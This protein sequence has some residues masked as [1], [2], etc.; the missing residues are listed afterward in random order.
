M[1]KDKKDTIKIRELSK[2][3]LEKITG[4]FTYEGA[5]GHKLNGVEITCPSCGTGLEQLIRQY[6]NTPSGRQALFYCY[7][8][9]KTFLY[10][11]TDEG[12][13]SRLFK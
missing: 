3:E 10:E 11:Y 4:G 13:E 1:D 7:V 2:D 6:N 12:I 5:P 8:C 9:N